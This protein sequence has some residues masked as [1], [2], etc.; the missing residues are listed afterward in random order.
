[1]VGPTAIRAQARG[2][3]RP[4]GCVRRAEKDNWSYEH[5][6]SAALDVTTTFIGGVSRGAFRAD[7]Q[8]S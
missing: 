4:D 3:Q 5:P 1:M 8:T 2:L 6:F 7:A